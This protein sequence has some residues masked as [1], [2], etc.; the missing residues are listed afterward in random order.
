M[1]GIN[2]KLAQQ[3]ARPE[4]VPFYGVLLDLKKSFDAMDRER[5]LLILEGYG[6][7]PNM[8]CLIQIFCATQFWSAKHPGTTNSRFTRVAV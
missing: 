6:V 2:A 3:L 7:G 8:I 5:C 4:Q 1:A